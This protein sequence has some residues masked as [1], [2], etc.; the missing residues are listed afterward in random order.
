M[1][2]TEKNPRFF[3]GPCIPFVWFDIPMVKPF[4]CRS[5]P[6]IGITRISGFTLIELVVT[7][8]VAS[9]LMVITTPTM[10]TFIQNQRISGQV[11]DLLGDLNIARSEAIRRATSVTVCKSTNPQA[12]TPACNPAGADWTTGRVIFADTDADGTIDAGEAVLRIREGLDGGTNTLIGDGTAANRVTFAGNGISTLGAEA[13]WKLCD[14]RGPGDGRAV[15]ISPTGRARVTDKGK[16]KAGDP[17]S[18][19]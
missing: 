18:C 16:D 4:I 19:T 12:A 13:E 3:I 15:A 14:S 11:N 9:T 7:L 6:F 8:V 1:T 5:R 2:G 17:L 10:R